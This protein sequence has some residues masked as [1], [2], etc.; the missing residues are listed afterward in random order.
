MSDLHAK[1]LLCFSYTLFLCL[2]KR[3]KSGDGTEDPS[4]AAAT[5]ADMAARR[6]S[7]K[8]FSETVAL[9][10]ADSED[11]LWIR[12]D[13]IYLDDSKVQKLCVALRRN[14]HML[15]LDLSETSQLPE[16]AVQAICGALQ[17]G[18]ASDLIELKVPVLTPDGM[19]AVRKVERARKNVRVQLMLPPP[20]TGA[21]VAPAPTTSTN[22]EATI[23]ANKASATDGQGYRDSAIVR[24]YF[25]IDDDPSEASAGGT[26]Q[27][28]DTEVNAQDPEQL[29]AFL[30]DEVSF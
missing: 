21:P 29:C 24:K 30:W 1:F 17:D 22:R 12:L 28:D 18:G 10:S 26:N 6:A 4:T 2:Q 11:E 25:Q 5:A 13:G 23:N 14:T 27:L 15:S 9:I 3:K 20:P 16:G 8:R 7:D 19:K